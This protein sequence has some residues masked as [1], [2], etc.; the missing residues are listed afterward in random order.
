M[1]STS[2]GREGKRRGWKAYVNEREGERKWREGFGPPNNFGMVPPANNSA[3]DAHNNTY[4]NSMSKFK[5]PDFSM[6]FLEL[7]NSP[8]FPGFPE[9]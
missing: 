6:S 3:V 4:E 5:I 7:K 9:L 2:M 8:S 1:G